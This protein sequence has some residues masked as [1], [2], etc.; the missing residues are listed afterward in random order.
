MFFLSLRT[1]AVVSG[2]GGWVGVGVFLSF[3][4]FGGIGEG[5]KVGVGVSVGY[6]GYPTT[7]IVSRN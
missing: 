5:V 7:L 2:R 4:T 3:R 6:F 1:F